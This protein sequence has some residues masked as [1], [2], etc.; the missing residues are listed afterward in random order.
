MSAMTPSNN[1]T[2]LTDV[3][4]MMRRVFDAPR[5]RVFNTYIDPMAIPGWWGPVNTTTRVERMEVKPGGAWRFIQRDSDGNEYAFRGEYREVVPPV[6]LVNTFE[7][8]PMAG[9]VIVETA[10]F[11]ELPDGKTQ[12]TVV[13]LFASKEDR[14]GMINSGMEAGATDSWDRLADYLAAH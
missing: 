7:F 12:V 11:E 2:I 6:R 13:S 5:E 10:T 3:E 14:D 4:I 1:L 9:H 8:E